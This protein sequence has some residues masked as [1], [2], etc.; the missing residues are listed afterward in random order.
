MRKFLPSLF[1][2][3]ILASLVPSTAYSKEKQ[4]RKTN[5]QQQPASQA[6]PQSTPQASP[7]PTP[8]KIIQG[9]IVSI[10]ADFITLNSGQPPSARTYKVTQNT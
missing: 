5:P 2:F 1:C 4:L 7:S 8:Q 9:T 6:T 3:L 10:G